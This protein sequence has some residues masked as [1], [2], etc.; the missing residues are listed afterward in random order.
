MKRNYSLS[1]RWIYAYN[2][3]VE[4]MNYFVCN[5]FNIA[6]VKKIQNISQIF[7]PFKY[8]QQKMLVFPRN[9]RKK[10]LNK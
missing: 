8:L 5:I 4:N 3:R 6:Y 10:S 2:I 1:Q 7:L 9:G